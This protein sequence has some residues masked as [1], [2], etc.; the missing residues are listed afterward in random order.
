MN[1]NLT[2]FYTVL[3]YPI[4]FLSYIYFHSYLIQL[5]LLRFHPVL[6]HPITSFFT[7]PKTSSLRHLTLTYLT[8]PHLTLPYLISLYHI[9]FANDETAILAAKQCL[10]GMMTHSSTI[11]KQLYNK[12]NC[13]STVIN[14]STENNCIVCHNILYNTILCSTVTNYSLLQ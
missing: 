6:P 4:L 7:F 2:F 14:L 1:L 13:T 5:K 9:I 8:S 11:L 3:S 10:T 12:L